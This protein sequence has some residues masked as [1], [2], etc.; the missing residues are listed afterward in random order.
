ME[1]METLVSTVARRACMPEIRRRRGTSAM[2][3]PIDSCMASSLSDMSRSPPSDSTLWFGSSMWNPGLDTGHGKHAVLAAFGNFGALWIKES[4]CS[5]NHSNKDGALPSLGASE[6]L[7]LSF[8]LEC[9]ACGE[10]EDSGVSKGTPSESEAQSRASLSSFRDTFA[11]TAVMSS[12]SPTMCA[13]A[14]VNLSSAGSGT[15]DAGVCGSPYM[16]SILRL[17]TCVIADDG[18]PERL[19]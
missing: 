12:P 1:H 6:D 8:S 3:S 4:R 19:K 11:T 7:D 17:R 18:G 13:S 14:A 5:W 10:L 9:A 15:P 16:L 2:V